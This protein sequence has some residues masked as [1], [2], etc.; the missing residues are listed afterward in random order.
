MNV[1]PMEAVQESE[2]ALYIDYVKWL[3]ALKSGE[4]ETFE[5]VPASPGM[6]HFPGLLSLI[7]QDLTMRFFQ[8]L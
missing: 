6:G 3:P 4:E 1:L 5:V 7:S 8:S 2:A